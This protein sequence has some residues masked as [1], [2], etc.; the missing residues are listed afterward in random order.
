MLPHN[1]VEFL[2][3]KDIARKERIRAEKIFVAAG[4]GTLPLF[5]SIPKD[6]CVYR[7]DLQYNGLA[8]RTQL[9][10]TPE[11][12]LHDLYQPVLLRLKPSDCAKLATERTVEATDFPYAICHVGGNAHPPKRA[13]GQSDSAQGFTTVQVPPNQEIFPAKLDSAQICWRLFHPDTEDLS[14]FLP[15]AVTSEMVV[16]RDDYM[17]RITP[18]KKTGSRKQDGKSTARYVDRHER[19]RRLL[20]EIAEKLAVDNESACSTLKGWA[21]TVY[22]FRE[23]SRF[24][25]FRLVK[26]TFSRGWLEGL[27]RE[28]FEFVQ[29]K[30]VKKTFTTPE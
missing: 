12:D 5:V 20:V 18:L 27:L 1:P 26:P 17:G 2:K 19:L 21:D 8:S 22:E 9:F 23:T 11:Y 6:L 29:G 15:L 25:E 13:D 24:A 16:T 4:Q 10:V 14:N 3:V 30:P 7:I 28:R